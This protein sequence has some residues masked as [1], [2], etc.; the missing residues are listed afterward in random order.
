MYELSVILIIISI[1]F[2]GTLVKILKE[3]SYQKD[4]WGD[5]EWDEEA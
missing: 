4:L 2:L 5:E 1:V 3:R